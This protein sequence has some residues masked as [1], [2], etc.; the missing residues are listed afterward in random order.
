MNRVRKLALF[1][2]LLLGPA[3][4]CAADD[5]AVVVSQATY[6]D[7]AWRE[8]VDALVAKHKATVIRYEKQPEEALASL[9]KQFP[10]WICF[11]ATSGE[12]S[13]EFVTRVHR[14][15]R[16]LDDDVY[17][18]ALWGILT[19]YDANAALRIARQA[20]PLEVK[21][22]AAG[23]EVDLKLCQQGVWYSE[24]KQ[25]Q[26]VR[27]EP[28]GKPEAGE[29]PADTTAVLAG[30]LNDGHTDLFVTSGHA[31]ERDWQIG[32]SY[33]NGSFRSKEGKLFGVDTAGKRIDIESS[34]P[35]V[36]LPIGNCL[37]GH[38]DG[39]DAMALAW[40][41][42]VGVTQMIGYTVPTWY[43]YGG[44]GLLDY[45]LEQPGRYSLS[46]AFFVNE[47]ALL[48][49]LETN[50]PGL[51]AATGPKVE[52][53]L[54]EQARANGLSLQDAQG[55][56]YDRDT[57]A[58]YGDPAWQAHM[59]KADCAFD[60]QLK[61]EDGKYTLEIK[62][63]SP[64]AFKLA[65]GNGSQ[66]GG[67]PIVQLLPHRIDVKSLRI[68]AGADL[69]PTITDNFILVPLPTASDPAQTC[70]ITFEADRG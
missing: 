65:S 20:Q 60:L 19:G 56:L 25:G 34:N 44:W 14:L 59:A 38:I 22:V 15:T 6:G 1:G 31:T 24:V 17:T 29:G 36:Y 8:V 45:F 3:I 48:H 64:Q 39:P 27:K 63:N 21:K 9:Q 18:D 46:E 70:H 2:C 32:F 30:C 53:T 7:T 4:A 13:R 23:T 58:F 43:G 57:V 69:H 33:P 49:R 35:K 62:P 47:Q 52:V 28:G 67:R 12:A 40:M 50:F 10:R 16:Q 11:V 37:M 5:Y 55:L 51:A 61:V 54:T 41:N 66:R 42:S 26:M 68:T